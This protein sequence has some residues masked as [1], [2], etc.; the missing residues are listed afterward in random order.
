VSGRSHAIIELVLAFAAAVGC[1]ASGLNATSTVVVPPLEDGD[2]ATT[3]V[4]YYPPLLV[5]ALIPGTLA[6]VLLVVGIARLR[7]YPRAASAPK[8]PG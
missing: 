7:R 2:P 4:A 8:S 3:S 1:V 6:G 5:L